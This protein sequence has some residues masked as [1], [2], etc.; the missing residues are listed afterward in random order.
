MWA[1]LMTVGG[2]AEEE[3]QKVERSFSEEFMT[4]FFEEYRNP[5]YTSLSSL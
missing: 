1:S 4:P 5:H 2:K 3:I